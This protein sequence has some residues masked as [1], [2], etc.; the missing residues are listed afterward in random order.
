VDGQPPLLAAQPFVQGQQQHRPTADGRDER[1]IE[2][3][4]A[5]GL[6]DEVGH[7]GRHQR[8]RAEAGEDHVAGTREVRRD[9]V[10]QDDVHGDQA[11]EHDE[12]ERRLGVRGPD[13]PDADRHGE[14]GEHDEALGL[15]ELVGRQPRAQIGILDEERHRP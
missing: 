7:R 5:R 4:D 10:R 14:A 1:A 12:A 8:V 15:R 6:A 3:G 11:V 13:V 2:H 9:A